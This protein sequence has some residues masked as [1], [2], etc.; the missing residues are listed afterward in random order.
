MPLST[1]SGGTTEARVWLEQDWPR[2]LDF[3]KN[4]SDDTNFKMGEKTE[5]EMGNLFHLSTGWLASVH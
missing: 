1:L 3:L 2:D 5:T 4:S